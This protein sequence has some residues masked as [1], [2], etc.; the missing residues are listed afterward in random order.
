MNQKKKDCYF[1]N[2]N[3]EKID[4]KDV[5]LLQRF[6]TPQGKIKPPRK[7][8]LCTKHQRLL[9]GTVKKSR[10]MALLPFSKR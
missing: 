10:T 9:A 1:C 4:Y 5:N 8:G 3:V 2:N 6:T 7:T